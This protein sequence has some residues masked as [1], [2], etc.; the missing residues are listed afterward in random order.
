MDEQKAPKKLNIILRILDFLVTLA[1]IAGAIFLIANRDQLSMDAVK[2]YFTYRSLE[3]SDSGQ[4][5]SFDYS[6]SS[7]DIFALL[8][9]DLLVCSV[10]GVHLYSGG[11]VCYVDDPMSLEHPAIEVCGETA[12]VWSVGGNSIFLYRDR[13]RCGSLED[14]SSPLL[15]VRLNPAGWLAVTTRESGYKAVVTIYDDQLVK[16]TAFRLSSAFVT[17]AVLTDD[18][19]SLAA[20][21]IRQNGTSFESSLSLYP[22][23]DLETGGVDYELTPSASFPLG[24]NVI[25]DMKGGNAIWCL[26]DTGLS[27]LQNASV[28][29]WSYQE[30]HLKNYAFSDQFTAVLLGKYRAGSQAELYTV[31]PQGNPSVARI[32]NEQ[33][34]SLSA[35]GKYVAVLTADRLDI[36]TQD[37]DLY[38]TL[39]G[40]NGAKKVLMREDGTALLIGHDTAHLYVP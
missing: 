11:G 26:G 29:S 35:C 22:L 27:A 17:D 16:R 5:E 14:L 3:R 28:G 7:T 20:V 15:S 21:S 33:I 1:L 30:E 8:G 38:A 40:T 12:A 19:K 23:P 6:P 34:L 31:D 32:M 2:R 36:Y 24:N 10:G 9:D 4:A 18:N 13:I 25:L 39:N 37:L